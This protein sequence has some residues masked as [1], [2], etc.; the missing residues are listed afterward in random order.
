MNANK[1]NWVLGKIS[2]V[3]KFL[4]ILIKRNSNEKPIKLEIKEGPLQKMPP[5]GCY[6]ILATNYKI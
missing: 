2:T 5:E 1:K 4:T 6:R 3:D